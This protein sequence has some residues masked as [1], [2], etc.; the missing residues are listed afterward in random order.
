MTYP[1]RQYLGVMNRGT[2][3]KSWVK[4]CNGEPEFFD[5][6]VTRVNLL[7]AIGFQADRWEEWKALEQGDYS[8]QVLCQHISIA[9]RVMRQKK[10]EVFLTRTATFSKVFVAQVPYY[11][12]LLSR[13][14]VTDRSHIAIG[15]VSRESIWCAPCSAT[16]YSHLIPIYILL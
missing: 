7:A 11:M 5:K 6:F 12:P 14:G 2:A 10:M 3:P 13:P 15:R 8:S 1:L 9:V 4:D 16:A